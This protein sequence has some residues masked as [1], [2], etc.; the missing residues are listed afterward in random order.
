MTKLVALCKYIIATILVIT[1]LQELRFI[2]IFMK[3]NI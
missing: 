2:I 3:T 1:R